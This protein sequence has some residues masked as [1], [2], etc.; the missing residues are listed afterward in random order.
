MFSVISNNY[1]SKQWKQWGYNVKIINLRQDSKEWHEFRQN[2][3]GSSDI[4][5]VMGISPYK[6][7][8]SLWEEKTG[9]TPFPQRPNLAMQHGKRE[10]PKA[11]AW[12]QKH[13]KKDYQPIVVQHD[14]YPFLYASLDAYSRLDNGMIEIK[15][16]YSAKNQA[17]RAYED[18]PEYWVM[19]AVYQQIFVQTEKCEILIWADDQPNPIRIPISKDLQNQMIEKAKHF[20]EYNV[21]CDFLPES[22]NT[23]LTIENQELE[24]YLDLYSDFQVQEKLIKEKKESVKSKILSFCN[25][26]DS[27]ETKSH[28]ITLYLPSGGYDYKKMI[29][30]NIDLSK[31]KKPGKETYMIRAKKAFV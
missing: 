24:T 9:R 28:N 20:W 7:A 6:S 23:K 27:Y 4:A 16:P 2:G 5:T 12:I 13:R 19:Q 17:I 26:K 10:E 21:V 14:Q 22:G 3:I 29:S 31:Y 30:D 8:Y 1:S 18:L 15:A 25:G 11:L